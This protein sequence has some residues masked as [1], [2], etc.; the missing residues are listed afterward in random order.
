MYRRTR[1]IRILRIHMLLSGR[2]SCKVGARGFG[3][4]KSYGRER[5][6]EQKPTTIG[7]DVYFKIVLILMME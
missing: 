7:D 2:R 3:T 4:V 5:Q 6:I 1:G